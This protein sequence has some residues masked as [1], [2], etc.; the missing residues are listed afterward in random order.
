MCSSDL[1]R[2]RITGVTPI[3]KKGFNVDFSTREIATDVLGR[4]KTLIMEDWNDWH[5]RPAIDFC[6]EISA[7][8]DKKSESEMLEKLPRASTLPVQD[9]M[10][11]E[12][13]VD[14]SGLD[15]GEDKVPGPFPMHYDTH[16]SPNTS[17]SDSDDPRS[18]RSAPFEHDVGGPP[19]ANM[20]DE[21]REID[22]AI[23][24]VANIQRNALRS[25]KAI[26]MEIRKPEEMSDWLAQRDSNISVD[27][28]TA[29]RHALAVLWL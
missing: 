29:K 20:I 17:I 28:G 24:A 14:L 7:T 4:T 23:W 8:V 16:V 3:D 15:F 26:T 11:E 12:T 1:D 2:M 9:L 22:E 25:G 21:I 18:F 6:H 27:E 19:G 5:Q 13:L 10:T